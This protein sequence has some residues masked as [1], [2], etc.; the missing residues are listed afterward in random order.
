MA[1]TVINLFL[2]VAGLKISVRRYHDVGKSGGTLAAITGGSFA[3]MLLLVFGIW[4]ALVDAINGDS[5]PVGPAMPLLGVGAFLFFSC[6][7]IA[8]HCQAGDPE[9]N[10]YD[11]RH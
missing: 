4:S 10:R 3:G 11:S 9:A 1:T 8:L 5:S 6:W 7:N 2:G